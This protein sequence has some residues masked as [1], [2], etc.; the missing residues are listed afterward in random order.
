MPGKPQR[1][2]A[3]IEFTLVFTLVF[4]VFWAL[5][6]YTIPLILLQAMNR[7]V[8]EGARVGAAIPSATTDYPAVVTSQAEA[9]MDRQMLWLIRWT[10]GLLS[11]ATFIHDANCPSEAPCV[12][13]TELRLNDYNRVARLKPLN[14]PVLG[15]VPRLPANLVATTRVML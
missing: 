5:M 14:L 8:G 15:Q 6:S 13:E 12:L 3:M 11:T 7:A 9:E 4:G 1:G 10:P 2:V